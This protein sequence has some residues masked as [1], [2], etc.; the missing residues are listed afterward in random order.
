MSNEDD[1]EWAADMRERELLSRIDACDVAERKQWQDLFATM[2]QLADK[3]DYV[4]ELMV[5]YNGKIDKIGLNLG[6]RFK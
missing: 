2:K 3:L 6:I 1:K 5:E 4:H